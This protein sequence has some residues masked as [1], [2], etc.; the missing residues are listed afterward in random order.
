MESQIA[1]FLS[2]WFFFPTN[3]V[4]FSM[5]VLSHSVCIITCW[6]VSLLHQRGE[7]KDFDSEKAGLMKSHAN[8]LPLLSNSNQGTNTQW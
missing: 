7:H 2:L 8:A 3:L 5:V 1:V 4:S 6:H